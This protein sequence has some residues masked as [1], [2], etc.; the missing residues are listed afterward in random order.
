MAFRRSRV[1]IP[2]APPVTFSAKKQRAIFILE[3]AFKVDV[4]CVLTCLVKS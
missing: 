4:K 3:F 1:R 2:P